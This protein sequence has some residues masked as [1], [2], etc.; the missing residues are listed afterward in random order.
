MK[1]HGCSQMSDR[2]IS[3]MESRRSRPRLFS[4]LT[5]RPLV[6]PDV[7]LESCGAIV[8]LCP[9]NM[10]HGPVE[11]SR[12]VDASPGLW[13]I[14][15]AW[16]VHSVLSLQHILYPLGRNLLSAK[17]SISR[18]KESA[19]QDRCEVPGVQSLRLLGRKKMGSEEKPRFFRRLRLIRHSK[20][21]GA[22]YRPQFQVSGRF[23]ARKALYVGENRGDA[24]NNLPDFNLVAFFMG[25]GS[26][27]GCGRCWLWRCRKSFACA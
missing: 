25:F 12:Q 6:M 15:C 13:L 1:W 20:R 18:H 4:V 24:K 26:V 16:A 3:L 23:L 11:R 8:N 14:F 5:P 27:P 22:V 17:M 19:A 10:A 2:A 7:A 9:L 21:R